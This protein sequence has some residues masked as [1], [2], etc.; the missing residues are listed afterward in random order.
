M[1]F[2]WDD[3]KAASNL[4]KHGVSFE[5][6]FN[7]DWDT[8]PVDEDSRFDY[9]EA[10]YIAYARAQDGNRY[11]VAFTLRSGLYRIISLRPFGRKEL[12]E[13]GES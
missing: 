13:Y 8:C 12:K 9:G 11:V 4:V 2:D 10:R 7:L 1:E 3:D 6:V 5:V